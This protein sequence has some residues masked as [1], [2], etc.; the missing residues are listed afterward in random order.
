MEQPRSLC[1]SRVQCT[2]MITSRTKKL[3]QSC[4]VFLL[5]RVFKPEI[6]QKTLLEISLNTDKPHSKSSGFVVKC[7]TGMEYCLFIKIRIVVGKLNT[8]KKMKNKHTLTAWGFEWTMYQGVGKT[9]TFGYI[10]GLLMLRSR[11]AK[12]A[13]IS[14][15]LHVCCHVS[16]RNHFSTSHT[17]C[18]LSWQVSY[19]TQN[20][21]AF[22]V[23]KSSEF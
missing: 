21:C 15:A 5:V 1:Y 4:D 8:F 9:P 10:L 18:D 2:I 20:C 22:S 23:Q 12:M 3:I 19:T 17:Q 16:F 11:R 7:N 6:L 13:S 14:V